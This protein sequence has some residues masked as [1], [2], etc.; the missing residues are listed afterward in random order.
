MREDYQSTQL[1]QNNDTMRELY[2]FEILRWKWQP[3]DTLMVE[4]PQTYCSVS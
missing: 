1:D 2:E 3:N 4:T